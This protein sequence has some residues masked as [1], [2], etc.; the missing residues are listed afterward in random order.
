MLDRLLEQ[1]Y[2][3]LNLGLVPPE[4]EKKSRAVKIGELSFSVKELDP[5]IF[6]FGTIAPPAPAKKEEFFTWIMKA[7]FLGQGTGG[8]AIGLEEDESVLTLSQA[9]PYD[10]NYKAFKEALED[11]AN[12]LQ[13]WKKEVAR[14]K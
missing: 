11:F 5:G 10:M 6:F 9:L 13:Y 3:E 1:L 7:N 2:Q 8:A 12:F 4:D 14:F